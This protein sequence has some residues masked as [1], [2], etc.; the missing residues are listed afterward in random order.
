MAV[1]GIIVTIMAKRIGALWVKKK[2][3]GDIFLIGTIDLGLIHGEIQIVA[4]KNDKKEKKNHPDYIVNLFELKKEDTDVG[5]IDIE[6]A[7]SGKTNDPLGE[8]IPF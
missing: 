5:A 2:N 7:G 3:D 1:E 6:E 4:W 8:D